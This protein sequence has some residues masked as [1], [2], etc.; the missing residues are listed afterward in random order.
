MP[1]VT[2]INAM[3]NIEKISGGAIIDNGD[4][5]SDPI[6]NFENH[7]SFCSEAAIQKVRVADGNSA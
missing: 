6:Q 3:R 7:T 1:S 5:H 2:Q 4:M